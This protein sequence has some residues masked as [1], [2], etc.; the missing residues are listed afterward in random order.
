MAKNK[1][2]SSMKDDELIG[3]DDVKFE[4]EKGGESGEASSGQ[5]FFEKNRNMLLIGGVVI[6]AIGGYFF[7]QNSQKGK[8][9]VEAQQVMVMPVLNY[10]QDSTAKAIAGFDEVAEDFSG[11]KTGN[12][13]RYYLGTSYLKSGNLEEGIEAL[14]KY[15]KGKSMISAAAHG[16]LGY[17]YEQKS[18]FEAAAKS[19][20]EAAH[21]PEDN[22][23]ST[24][25]Y[26]MHAARNMQSAGK[27]EEAVAVYKEI[28]EKF[29]VSQEVRDGRV[30]RYLSM[31]S[32]DDI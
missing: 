7:Y 22:T 2:R 27:T 13:A 3:E 12:L 9:D 23:F 25:F 8:L 32:E 30:D 5:S 4:E 1:G 14:E 6:A 24:P 29:P 20:S 19:Y 15:K 31:L 21:T 16:A 28:K 17:A 26:L 10:E 18:D 11:T